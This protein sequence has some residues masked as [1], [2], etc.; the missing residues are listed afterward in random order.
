MD[1]DLPSEQPIQGREVTLLEFARLF[2]WDMLTDPDV[3]PLFIAW[4]WL[5]VWSALAS[6]YP[7]T[8][9]PGWVVPG[10]L[11]SGSLYAL[12][13]WYRRYPS[14]AIR[15]IRRRIIG[16]RAQQAGALFCYL[17]RG[18][19]KTVIWLGCFFLECIARSAPSTA[20]VLNECEGEIRTLATDEQCV[21]GA[22]ADTPNSASLSRL[23]G[24][25][26][27]PERALSLA[28]RPE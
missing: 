1:E 9:P 13:A 25:V 27:V 15:R 17:V 11:V 7:T 5:A 19:L 12:Q 3:R 10:A 21:I 24:E 23:G 14:A 2:F 26:E 8:L 22:D 4:V 16:L 20:Q 28:Q 18:I 6:N